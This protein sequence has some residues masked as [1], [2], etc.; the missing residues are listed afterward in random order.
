MRS[1]YWYK[2]RTTDRRPS[3]SISARWM[4][5]QI[6]WAREYRMWWS[7]EGGISQWYCVPQISG[8]NVWVHQ[9]TLAKTACFSLIC[10]SCT[11]ASSLSSHQWRSARGAY[12]GGKWYP[13][14]RY[15]RRSN[16]YGW[17]CSGLR[18]LHLFYRRYRY[19]WMSAGRKLSQTT[20]TS[21]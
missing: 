20:T 7:W 14:I 10:A 15:S 3:H 2:M 19:R 13:E 9:K 17:I 21:P 8:E 11:S 4:P 12:R 1:I 16:R 6:A 5:S 18:G